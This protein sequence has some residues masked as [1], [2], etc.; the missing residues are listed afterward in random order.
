[1]AAASATYWT[2]CL[3]FLVLASAACK[4]H[5][6]HASNGTV[7]RKTGAKH[8]ARSLVVA[9]DVPAGF[10]IDRWS[11]H[12][13]DVE[14]KLLSSPFSERF[15]VVDNGLLMTTAKL[16]GLSSQP[17]PLTLYL[18]EESPSKKSTHAVQLYVVDRDRMIRFV[19]PTVKALVLENQTPGTLV[20]DAIAVVAHNATDG[21]VKFDIVGH[22]AEDFRIE[23]DGVMRNGTVTAR[24]VTKNP[25]DRE[26]V[27]GYDLIVRAKSSSPPGTATCRLFV[28]VDD[29]NDNRPIFTKAEFHFELYRNASRFDRIGRVKATDADDD[30]L[31][32]KLLTPSNRFVMIPQTGEIILATT[33]VDVVEPSQ[34]NETYALEATVK[35]RRSPFWEAEHP[36]RIVIR[37]V[38][39]DPEEDGAREAPA[40]E[41]R[42]V[43]RRAPRALRPT[44]RIEFSEAD[45]A[46]EG[47]LMFTLDKPSEKERFKI[48][49]DNPWVTVE[50]N[51]NVRVK[52]KW[53]YE[54]LGPEKTIDFWVTITNTEGA[55]E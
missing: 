37:T 13:N 51:G 22:G 43:K 46:P 33:D 14:Y 45:G 50:P 26:K 30:R 42:V 23:T 7:H 16:D 44:K 15:T 25:L 52:R 54:E 2:V 41:H 32:F 53:D 9:H 40:A 10:S 8:S 11:S 55:G 49:D 6:K 21:K 20:T 28:D 31:V 5:Q 29:A 35:D 4:H 39:D 38:D 47:K 17:Q 27:N 1:M 18:A 24:V 36:A 3:L 19:Q 34:I 48:R 12:A